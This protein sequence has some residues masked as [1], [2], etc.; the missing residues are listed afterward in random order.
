MASCVFT[1]LACLIVTRV[2]KGIALGVISGTIPVYIKRTLPRMRATQLLSSVQSAIPFGLFLMSLFASQL[3]HVYQFNGQWF[4]L[5]L[6]LV[7]AIL[8]CPFI[9][10]PD[11]VPRQAMLTESPESGSGKRLYS[12]TIGKRNVK[13]SITAA[14]LTQIGAQF[15]GINMIGKTHIFLRSCFPM[16]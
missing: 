7:P 15:T 5:G 13:R 16:C 4:I 1:T 3:R 14:C 8:F 2:L 9:E 10:Q 6:L 11:V 12:S